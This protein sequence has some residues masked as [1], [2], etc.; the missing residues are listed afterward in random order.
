MIAFSI[1]GLAA[2]KISHGWG[3][4]NVDADTA[5]SI[6]EMAWLHLHKPFDNDT[7]HPFC[8]AA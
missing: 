6:K 7:Y 4:C 8:D 3:S 5:C 2:A 1:P